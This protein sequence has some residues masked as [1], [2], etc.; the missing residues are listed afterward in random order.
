MLTLLWRWSFLTL[1]NHKAFCV[2]PS[3]EDGWRTFGTHYEKRSTNIGYPAVMDRAEPDNDVKFF[4]I[5]ATTQ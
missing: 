5:K 3:G 4:M 2:T 1:S